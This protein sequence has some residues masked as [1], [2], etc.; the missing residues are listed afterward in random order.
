M[1]DQKQEWMTLGFPE[2]DALLLVAAQ[3]LGLAPPGW[4]A[5]S[6]N[7]TDGR[8]PWLFSN[9]NNDNGPDLSRLDPEDFGAD[10]VDEYLKAF[11]LESGVLKEIA[12]FIR[13][14]VPPDK[15]FEAL[16][17]VWELADKANP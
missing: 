15:Q 6:K 1:S 7:K 8:N 11:E 10:K 12:V 4:A 3:E 2:R 17:L 16:S 5:A 9:E 14:S 13:S